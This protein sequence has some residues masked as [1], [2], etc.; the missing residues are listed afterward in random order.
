[1]YLYHFSIVSKNP[2]QDSSSFLIHLWVL[3]LGSHIIVPVVLS[4][5]LLESENLS[6]EIVEQPVKKNKKNNKDNVFFM[7]V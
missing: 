2:C 1:V 7:V 4:I 6:N 3:S 5:K